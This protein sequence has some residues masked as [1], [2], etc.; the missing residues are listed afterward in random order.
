MQIQPG[1]FIQLDVHFGDIFFEV[2]HV[3]NGT[4][5]MFVSYCTYSKR[6]NRVRTISVV[7]TPDSV[8][9]IVA[10][11]MAEPVIMAKRCRFYASHGK[12]DPFY[13]YEP[14]E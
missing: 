8:R 14:A 13:G 1:D 5:P 9:R 7:V 4:G 11:E 6:S 10:K 3:F 12:Y 2:S